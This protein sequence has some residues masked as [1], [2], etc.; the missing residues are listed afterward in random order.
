[1]HL[2]PDGDGA[3]RAVLPHAVSMM[4]YRFLARSRTKSSR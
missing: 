4:K 2:V 3:E 1:M